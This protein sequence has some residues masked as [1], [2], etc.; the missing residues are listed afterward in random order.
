M[1]IKKQLLEEIESSPDSLLAETLDFLCFLKTKP[2]KFQQFY[3]SASGRSI[4]RHAGKW[5]GDDLEECLRSVY[6]T[7]GKAK[8]S[9]S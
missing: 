4:L 5:E 2:K 1:T 6:A 9:A 8:F 3:R 7:R